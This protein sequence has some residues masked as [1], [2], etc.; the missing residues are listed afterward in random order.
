MKVHLTGMSPRMVS[1]RA[2][3]QM[4]FSR[5]LGTALADSGHEVQRGSESPA[6]PDLVIAGV[7]SML[8]PGAT[9]ALVGLQRIGRALREETPLLLFVDDP[10]LA[11]TKAAALSVMR[12]PDRLFTPYL[13]SKRVK[14]SL[15]LR[16]A[17]ELDDI[18]AAVEMLA[19][20]HW[21][22]TLVPMHSW[23]DVSMVAQKLGTF[24]EVRA[25][26]LSSQIVLDEP[27]LAERTP[28]PMWFDERRYTDKLLPRGRTLWP[29]IPVD[30]ATMPSPVHVYEA[31]RG[32]HQGKVGDVVGWWTPTPVLVAQAR[33][34]YLTDDALAIGS[35]TPYYLT[36]DDVEQLDDTQHA[37]LANDQREHLKEH[38]WQQETLFSALA[39]VAG[40]ST[41]S[42][43]PGTRAGSPTAS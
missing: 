32:V 10:A 38:T 2:R 14:T 25:I 27:M 20:E 22:T 21:P 26:D 41:N 7:T 17:Q 36:V 8:S 31:V 16:S 19:S 24:S 28:V 11:K 13:L 37:T 1:Q 5:M 15:G 4:T 18:T 29:V 6:E 30:A 9:Y 43:T 34:V 12:S 35:D 40:R 33:T 42:T 39:D 23:G 3:E